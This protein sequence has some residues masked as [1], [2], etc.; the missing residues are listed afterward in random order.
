M[1]C[2]NSYGLLDLTNKQAQKRF[3][4]IGLIAGGG[5]FPL[6]L[7]KDMVKNKTPFAVMG[8]KGFVSSDIKKLAKSHYEE[9]FI[10]DFSKVVKFFKKERVNNIV[11]VGGVNSAAVRFNNLSVLKIF[12]KLFF[13]KKKHDGIFRVVIKEFED[14]GFGVVGAQDIMPTLMTKPGLLT[15]TKPSKQDLKDIDV[16]IIKSKELGN[17][18][19][20]QA[21]VVMNGV[22]IGDESVPGT[23]A[24]IKRCLTAKNGKSGGVMAKLTKP[25]QE[26]RCDIP[27]IGFGTV[28]NLIDGKIHGI[29][30]ESGYKTIIE[31]KEKLIK[32]ADKNKIFIMAI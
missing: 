1:G 6:L 8:I 12:T 3:G 28:Q 22:L 18:D 2:Y 24:L 25:G 31:E 30:I 19:L 10:T 21:A 26:E 15:K 9:G 14:K 29:I 27:A 17:T 11:I 16:A 32:F 4:K 13:Y 23:D 20:G 7:V 5:N